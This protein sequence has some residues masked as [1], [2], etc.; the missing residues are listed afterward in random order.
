MIIVECIV[1]VLFELSM[2]IV[3]HYWSFYAGNHRLIYDVTV[4]TYHGKLAARTRTSDKIV[5]I[6]SFFSWRPFW[7]PR[8]STQQA[9]KMTEM[10]AAKK[11]EK[12][13]IQ[14]KYKKIYFKDLQF[15]QEEYVSGL[16]LALYTNL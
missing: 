6:L 11:P 15:D 10:S 7:I 5:L 12:R 8:T 3:V 4:L 16:L 1:E 2:N 13:T 9:Y 14:V